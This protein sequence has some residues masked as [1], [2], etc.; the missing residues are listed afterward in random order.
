MRLCPR[1]NSV[2]DIVVSEDGREIG[3]H[4]HRCWAVDDRREVRTCRAMDCGRLF[5]VG[6]L[7]EIKGD[8]PGQRYCSEF[9]RGQAEKARRRKERADKRYFNIR[10]K[11]C[12]APIAAPLRKYCAAHRTSFSRKAAA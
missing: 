9:C 5:V 6:N 4:C 11:F 12:H 7:G 1:C 3:T 10:C 8:P 2:V